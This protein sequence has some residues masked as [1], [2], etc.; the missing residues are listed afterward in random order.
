MPL[1]ADDPLQRLG[2]CRDSSD[3]PMPPLFLFMAA[4]STA[5]S[6]IEYE[7]VYSGAPDVRPRPTTIIVRLKR[8]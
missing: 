8:D 2:F 4:G 3:P 5:T 7:L 1:T 6:G